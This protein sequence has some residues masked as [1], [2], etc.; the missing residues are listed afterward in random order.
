MFDILYRVKD[1][2]PSDSREL[3]IFTEKDASGC[4]EYRPT[5]PALLVSST[6][7]TGLH[8]G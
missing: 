7:W 1:A 6:S 5:R 2:E 3:T 8:M 4:I